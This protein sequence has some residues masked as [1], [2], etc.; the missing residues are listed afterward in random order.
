M[1]KLEDK[2]NSTAPSADYPFGKS[3]DNT[4]SNNGTPLNSATLEDYYQFF[5]KMFSESGITSNGL[6]DNESNGWQLYEAFRKLTKPYKVYTALIYQSGPS[7]APVLTE[8]VNELSG[9]LTSSRIT[10]G[11]YQLSLT[12]E[13]IYNKTV[14]FIS[15]PSQNV[16]STPVFIS[17]YRA[18]LNTINISTYQ[19]NSIDSTLIVSDSILS[20]NFIEIRVYD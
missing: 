19:E 1:I 10:T 5:E 14:V 6:L 20:N 4:G 12:D 15:Q 13:F 16:G 7:S 3:T 8:L 17:A 11:T 2:V 9:N 18:S